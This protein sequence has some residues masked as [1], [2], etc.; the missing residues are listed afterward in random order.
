MTKE[1]KASLSIESALAQIEEVV[2]KLESGE[3]DLEEAIK[4]YEKGME[5]IERCRG[6][7]KH[8][9]LRV[10]QLKKKAADFEGRAGG[11]GA[12]EEEDNDEEDDDDGEEK[13]DKGLF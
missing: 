13:N 9:K 5:L 2:E 3:I 4:D 10:E 8:S 1:K 11:A 7:L 12:D 6:I